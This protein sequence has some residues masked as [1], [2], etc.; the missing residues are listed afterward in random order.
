MLAGLL[1]II[2]YATSFAWIIAML[3]RFLELDAG[4]TDTSDALAVFL[5]PTLVFVIVQ[6]SDDWLL[7][8]WLQGSQLEMSFITII[9]VV[10]VGGAVAGLLG[11]LLAVPAAACLRILWVEVMKPNL[12]RFAESH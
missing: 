1:G 12:V 11:M 8:P 9:L 6:A 4:I 3:L 7:T 5:W 2:P 10:I